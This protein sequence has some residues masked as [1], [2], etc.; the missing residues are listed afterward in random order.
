VTSRLTRR[1]FLDAIAAAAATSSTACG[2]PAPHS[3]PTLPP[4]GIAQRLARALGPW[5]AHDV[6]KA[7]ALAGRIAEGI[8]R[9]DSAPLGAVVA[10]IP[11]GAFALDGVALRGLDAEARSTLVTVLEAIA[12]D[13][14]V[15]AELW[16]A[17]EVGVCDGDL[18]RH[19]R[20]PR[21]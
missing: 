8:H 16:G 3:A 9:L 2:A 11:E 12:H 13:M 6:A 4:L 19:T 7:D 1:A 21:S 10:R 20:P 14:G 5:K 17:A 18:V 15:L